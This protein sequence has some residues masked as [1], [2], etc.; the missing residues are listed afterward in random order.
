MSPVDPKIELH[1]HLEGTVRA[2]A[3]LRIARRNRCELPATTEAEL[4][5]LYAFRGKER[6]RLLSAA[7][8]IG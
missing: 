7:R 2:P 5:S 4:A 1:V 3:L 6:A 8:A